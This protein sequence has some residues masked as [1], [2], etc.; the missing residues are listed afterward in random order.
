MTVSVCAAKHL[1]F[2]TFTLKAALETAGCP[3]QA[4]VV[5]ELV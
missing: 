5:S 2:I 4:A 1:L 3:G